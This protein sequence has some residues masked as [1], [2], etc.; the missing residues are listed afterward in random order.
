MTKKVS[1]K[2]LKYI[3]DQQKRIYENLMNFRES[4]IEICKDEYFRT[5]MYNTIPFKD[6]LVNHMNYT[7]EEANEITQIC[8]K[9]DK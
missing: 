4:Y 2:E 6:F 7:E 1:K 3:K 8:K 9:Y 5:G